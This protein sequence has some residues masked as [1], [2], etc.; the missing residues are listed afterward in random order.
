[1][2]LPLG[3]TPPQA[4]ASAALPTSG[5]GQ[6]PASHV[7]EVEVLEVLLVV[8]VGEVVLLELFVVELEVGDDVVLVVAVVEV[9]V[10]LVDVLD[11][12]LAEVLVEVLV[13]VLVE[14]LVEVLV[15]VRVVLLEVVL[16]LVVVVVVSVLVIVLVVV[17]IVVLVLVLVAVLLVMAVL[18]AFAIGPVRQR[19]VRLGGQIP[20]GPSGSPDVVSMHWP[21]SWAQSAATW[22]APSAG[23]VHTQSE[24]W[25]HTSELPTARSRAT[26][27]QRSEAPGQSPRVAQTTTSMCSP[28]P[29]RPPQM[30][31]ELL[32]HL[33][34]CSSGASLSRTMHLSP[35]VPQSEG[36]LHA[37]TATLSP[38][39][40]PISPQIHAA[41]AGQLSSCLSGASLSTTMHW[42][43][44]VPQSEGVLHASTT[45]WSPLLSSPISPQMHIELVGQV[46]PWLS[47]ASL[48]TAMH[49]S[50]SAPQSEEVLHA[51]TATLSPV[52]P[53]ISPQMHVQLAGQVSSCLSGASISTTM[54]WSPVQQSEGVLHAR[55]VIWS[56]GWLPPISPQM[57]VELAGQ[58]SPWL[59]G[60]SLSMS[61]HWSPVAG[62]SKEVLHTRTTT[63]SPGVLSPRSAQM[64]VELAGQLP[65]ASRGKSLSMSRH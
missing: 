63:L 38:A 49:W 4:L 35:S 33:S 32:G 31:L 22:Q 57:H 9:E 12:V 65:M 15:V 14:V 18:V 42:S 13:Q 24:L 61:T 2:Q 59:S 6:A 62:Q 52:L 48:S 51:S 16:V 20:D 56:P 50:P 55:T 28:S 3:R 10:V 26:S 44:T 5:R 19:Q 41:P 40:P 23:L 45:T 7:V 30:H 17:L 1:M 27:T 37:R 43:P 39:L 58:A 25:G 64:H 11:V 8:V 36:V 29:S 53:P 54:H 21:P 46:S 34:P 47:G 60:A